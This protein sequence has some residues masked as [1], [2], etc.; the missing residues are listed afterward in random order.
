M[1]R[2]GDLGFIFVEH[3]KLDYASLQRSMGP[4]SV[5]MDDGK[6]KIFAMARSQQHRMWV[7]KLV[8]VQTWPL[9]STKLEWIVGSVEP[10]DFRLE[11]VRDRAA[12]RRQKLGTS[13]FHFLSRLELGRV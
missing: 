8:P 7:A 13:V 3:L 1:Y 5:D 6:D 4:T 11:K 2:K 12:R 10:A 9:P